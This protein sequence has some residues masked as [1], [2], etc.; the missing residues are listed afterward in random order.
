M[1]PD[2]S[3]LNRSMPSERGI[4]DK[5]D[6]GQIGSGGTA[7]VMGDHAGVAFCEHDRLVTVASDV[8]DLT[9]EFPI[10]CLDGDDD[11]GPDRLKTVNIDAP[12]ETF[13]G[14]PMHQ[15]PLRSEKRQAIIGEF[16]R[17][18]APERVAILLR[19]LPKQGDARDSAGEHRRSAIGDPYHERGLPFVTP[20][21]CMTGK[22]YA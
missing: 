13:P 22:Q 8:L 17:V 3:L 16:E 9:T 4:F 7:L 5:T 21:H 6:P 2:R 15:C 14:D 1:T 12:K 10:L 11:P 20:D 18:I 19:F